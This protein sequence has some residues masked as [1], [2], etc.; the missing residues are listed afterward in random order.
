MTDPATQ[1]TP[2]LSRQKTTVE[3]GHAKRRLN[4]RHSESVYSIA[5]S[6]KKGKTNPPVPATT[7]RKRPPLQRSKTLA[8]SETVSVK[9]SQEDKM[10]GPIVS[11]CREC[12]VMV[13]NIIM[14]SQDKVS[15]EQRR[16]KNSRTWPNKYPGSA[17][18]SWK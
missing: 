10:K 18:A 11:V 9:N 6:N 13:C 16:R 17:K 12:K 1:I 2:R 14:A 4:F 3:N 5:N 15:F 7:G 8:T